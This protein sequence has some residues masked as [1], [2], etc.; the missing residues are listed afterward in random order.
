MSFWTQDKIIRLTQLWSAGEL[1]AAEIGRELGCGKNAVVGK[2]HRLGLQK[3]VVT[4]FENVVVYP[5]I[6]SAQRPQPQVK[7]KPK[8]KT[9]P[10]LDAETFVEVDEATLLAI[11]EAFSVLSNNGC[12]YIHGFPSD[13]AM[14]FCG[15]SIKEGSSYCVEH[16]NKTHVPVE[17]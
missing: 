16:H 17:K 13:N 7:P 6:K 4:G 10:Q 14:R 12:R 11:D 5:Q 3:G 8:V 2:A 15:R 1:S 9:E